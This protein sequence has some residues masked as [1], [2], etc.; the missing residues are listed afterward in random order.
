MLL[1]RFSA[2]EA[3]MRAALDDLEERLRRWH[4]A[5]QRDRLDGGA[6]D[7]DTALQSGAA[8]QAEHDALAIELV[9]VR[10]AVA[11]TAE[12]LAAWNARPAGT[13]AEPLLTS[14]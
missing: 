8:L 1:H 3:G 5:T 7:G 6:D 11:G 12:E 10:L 14:A 4:E 9:H 2:Q 13:I